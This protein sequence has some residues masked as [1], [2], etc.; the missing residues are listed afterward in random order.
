MYYQILLARY[1]NEP[2]K[3]PPK[4][5]NPCRAVSRFQ[6]SRIGESAGRG[7]RGEAPGTR[8]VDR[9]AIV[10]WPPYPVSTTAGRPPPPG[11][12]TDTGRRTAQL[13]A[14]SLQKTLAFGDI[15]K[16]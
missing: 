9:G 14:P 2:F 15:I 13:I 12:G 11:G 7:S 6:R 8:G 3:C 1:H 4:A 16:Y 5:D 10:S